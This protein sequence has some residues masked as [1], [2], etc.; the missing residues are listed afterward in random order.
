MG[1]RGHGYGAVVSLQWR[2][3]QKAG[4]Q[5]AN[6]QN[7]TLFSAFNFWCLMKLLSNGSA[8][9]QL[10][11][12][13]NET[14]SRCWKD[15]DEFAGYQGWPFGMRPCS[16]GTD[17]WFTNDSTWV[18][19]AQILCNHKLEWQS[20]SRS[21]CQIWHLVL[22]YLLKIHHCG[23]AGV[24]SWQR[25][26]TVNKFVHCLLL[27]KCRNKSVHC[28]L[29]QSQLD[30]RSNSRC[31]TYWSWSWSCCFLGDDVATTGCCAVVRNGRGSE[32]SNSKWKDDVFR[33]SSMNFFGLLSFWLRFFESHCWS[34][35]GL[36]FAPGGAQQFAAS[37]GNE[38]H[39]TKRVAFGRTVVLDA[40]M[41]KT[42]WGR[43]SE[44]S[45]PVSMLFAYGGSLGWRGAADHLTKVCSSVGVAL[46]TF[47][48]LIGW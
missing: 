16:E 48:K 36:G 26:G 42:N 12:T 17:W 3:I 25:V 10:L 4:S 34:G 45:S 47:Q 23:H 1:V 9:L 39:V 29:V 11:I 44:G 33:F 27:E 6:I 40:C 38:Y 14:Y 13:C 20:Y 37:R 43:W 2:V 15:S 31:V 35:M 41:A 21:P 5:S 8:R 19:A 30:Q 24:A 7:G 32:M 28:L 18:H 46:A 22:R